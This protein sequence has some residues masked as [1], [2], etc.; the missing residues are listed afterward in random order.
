MS[1]TAPNGDAPLLSI[2]TVSLNAAASIGDTLASVRGQVVSFQLEHICVDGG[3]TDATREIVDR[4]AA[5]D[6][7]I[8]RVYE[9]DSGIFD[10]MNHGLAAAR[11][12]YLLFLNADDFLADPACL[13]CAIGALVPGGPENPH[14]LAGD[15]SMGRIGATGI[16]RHRRVP[17][18]LVAWR[19]TGLFPVHQGL[20]VRRDVLVDAG[21]FDATL[22]LA[23]DV[24]FYYELERR[25]P[26]V[27]RIL[28]RKIAFMRA[29]GAANAGIGAMLRGTLET[30]RHLARSRPRLRALS[31]VIVKTLQSLGE[32]RYGRCPQQRWFATAGGDVAGRG[33]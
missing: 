13:Q 30:Y 4:A 3:S 23:A 14:A 10:A 27:L 19:E 33:R 32:L 2:V 9:P 15:V 7:R 12:E 1:I 28:G 11:G 26:F 16:W 8:R 5:G 25:H 22:R 17:R 6:A 20:F 31:M 24:T 29:G 18:A 21:G